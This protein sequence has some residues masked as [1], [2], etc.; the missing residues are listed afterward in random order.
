MT[1]QQSFKSMEDGL[2][3]SGFD[4]KLAHG[5]RWSRSLSA[6][7]LL[8]A[9]TFIVIA[10]TLI[11]IPALV[12]LRAE[13][14]EQRV[15]AA[16]LAI[17][18]G[19]SDGRFTSAAS[20]GALMQSAGISAM[21]LSSGPDMLF[22]AGAP[23]EGRVT[24][25]DPQTESLG[26]AVSA[27][28]EAL[29]QAGSDKLLIEARP[30]FNAA[31]RLELV[32][33]T[34]SLK[35][36]TAREAGQVLTG[37]LAVAGLVSLFLLVALFDGLVQPMRA[38]TA[39]IVRFRNNPGDPANAIRPS[40]RTDEIGDAEQALADMQ[41][42]LRSAL[43]QQQRLAQMGMSVSKISHDLRHSLGSAQLVSER[44][45]L[46]DDPVV[47]RSLPRLERAL[48]RAAGLA[49]STL[50]Y[51]RAEE[52][53]PMVQPV[54]LVDLRD[55]VEDSAL[56]G[57]SSVSLVAD[58]PQP[59]IAV[60]A[61]PDHLHRIAT[62]LIRNAALAITASGRPGTVTVS[63]EAKPGRIVIRFADNGP[64]I[65]DR[66]RANLFVPWQA[67]GAS[68]GTG[69]GLA[70]ARELA[71]ANGGSLDLENT[72]PTG[73][74]FRLALPDAGQTVQSVQRT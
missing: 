29:F 34:A 57:T 22:A 25:V 10:E 37:T 17:L 18:A 72:G 40:G 42:A 70:I 53:P 64:G 45:A 54:R 73:T 74:V 65:P 27:S 36:A 33:S 16:E 15:T 21:R 49:E 38:L 67:A 1:V 4:R 23:P 69:L 58:C 20:Q 46:V 60:L 2:P 56:A 11:F 63:A 8:I 30:G 32:A 51:G 12:S 55:D 71:V 5:R 26:E 39:A 62:N 31:L 28:F 13:W 35:Q 61:D 48:E 52:R 24:R 50:R 44:L 6:R 3:R 66:V 68:G 7:L 41:S 14:I 19:A 9:A 43:L 47:Q 59:D